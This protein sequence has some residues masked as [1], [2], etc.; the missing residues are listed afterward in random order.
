MVLWRLDDAL[1]GENTIQVDRD[2]LQDGGDRTA[3]ITGA[4]CR[5]PTPVRA[6]SE[7]LISQGLL[8]L[9]GRS[10]RRVVDGEPRLDLHRYDDDVNADTD[11]NVVTTGDGQFV[12]VRH[13]RRRSGSFE[14]STL[15]ALPALAQSD[16]PN[17][18]HCRSR[19]GPLTAY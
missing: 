2:V 15:D 9:R 10:Q 11:M 1:L 17:R 16:A 6:Q 8:Q 4:I 12:E 19:R 5:G 3:A 18:L 7:G 14:R 13:R